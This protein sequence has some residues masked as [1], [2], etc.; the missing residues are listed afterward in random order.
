MAIVALSFFVVP[1]FTGISKE[2]TALVASTDATT[3]SNDTLSFEDIYEIADS[4]RESFSPTSLNN[5]SPAA[6][7]GSQDNF[8][9]GF[10]GTEDSALENTAPIIIEEI[11]PTELPN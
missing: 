7:I 10:S 3:P 4:N 8:S 5:I 6:G 1:V 9:I 11:A 2:H